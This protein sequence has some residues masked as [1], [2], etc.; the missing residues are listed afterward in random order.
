MVEDALK[1]FKCHHPG[2][3][4][5]EQG[6]RHANQNGHRTVVHRDFENIGERLVRPSAVTAIFLQRNILLEI[7]FNKSMAVRHLSQ[8]EVLPVEQCVLVQSLGDR[9]DLIEVGG[10]NDSL[11][12]GHWV[13]LRQRLPH[14]SLLN[15]SRLL[16]DL[17]L[18]FVKLIIEAAS[19]L[20]RRRENAFLVLSGFFNCSE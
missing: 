8:V 9:P 7:L 16:A 20:V 5:S 19:F 6:L 12:P 18:D 3:L 10:R 2:Q 1:L 4:H 13:H 11:A 17:V 14:I 15:L